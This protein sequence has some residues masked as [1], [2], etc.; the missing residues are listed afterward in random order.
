MCSNKEMRG[1]LAASDDFT[2]FY[3]TTSHYHALI[4]KVSLKSD[5]CMPLSYISYHDVYHD[6]L[7]CCCK[8]C[9]VI[10]TAL[11]ICGTTFLSRGVQS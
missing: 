7:A 8:K 10:S 2:T 5:N 4:L 3:V 11:F 1:V 9:S 6:R